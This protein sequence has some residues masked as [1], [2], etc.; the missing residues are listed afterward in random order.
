MV[1]MRIA[2][3]CGCAMALGGCLALPDTPRAYTALPSTAVS[4]AALPPVVVPGQVL[5]ASLGRTSAGVNP[6]DDLLSSERARIAWAPLQP[7]ELALPSTPAAHSASAIKAGGASDPASTSSV[8]MP[9]KGSA[10]PGADA[11]SYDREATMD[12]LEKEGRKDAKPI[13]GGC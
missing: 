9:T 3:L 2:T 11:Q 10:R 13:C 5:R 7:D 12:R 4:N 1:V 6:S 8:S